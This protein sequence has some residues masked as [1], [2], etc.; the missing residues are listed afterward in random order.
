MDY[1]RI[2]EKEFSNKTQAKDFCGN[3]I[4]KF[5]Y[6]TDKDD[7]WDIDHIIPLAENGSDSDDNKQ[8]V[9]RRTNVKKADKITYVIDDITYQSKKKKSLKPSDKLASYDYSKKV[10]CVVILERAK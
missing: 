8:I 1:D 6:R 3:K 5:E 10:N 4:S 2:W 7:S 9:N